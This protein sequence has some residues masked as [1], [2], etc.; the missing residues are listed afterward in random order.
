V[1]PDRLEPGRGGGIDLD[2]GCETYR[3]ALVVFS[4]SLSLRSARGGPGL[5]IVEL[6]V[7]CGRVRGVLGDLVEDA[8]DGE[9]QS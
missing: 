9:A 7:R 2:R 3:S 6:V 4:S 5:N 1:T 8:Y